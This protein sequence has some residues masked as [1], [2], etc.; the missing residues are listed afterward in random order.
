[1]DFPSGNPY[2]MD[3]IDRSGFIAA[4]ETVEGSPVGCGTS[5]SCRHRERHIG[6]TALI[7]S[8][9]G[10]QQ[11]YRIVIFLQAPFPWLETGKI[12]ASCHDQ[13]IS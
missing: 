7:L 6:D 3:S 8:V 10:R 11:I 5:S 9:T 1:M 4:S 2:R 13:R 12:R